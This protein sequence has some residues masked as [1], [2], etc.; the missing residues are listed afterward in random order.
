MK[1][2]LTRRGAYSAVPEQIEGRLTPRPLM[3]GRPGHDFC[4]DCHS[5]DIAVLTEGS[6]GQ[7]DQD[8]E[9]DCGHAWSL[10]GGFVEA[11]KH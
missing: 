3:E 8:I 11:I 10:V 6:H 4:P 2:P 7:I 1:E 5:E 9:C